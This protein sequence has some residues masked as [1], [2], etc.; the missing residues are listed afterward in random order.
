MKSE[1]HISDFIDKWPATLRAQLLHSGS[2]LELLANLGESKTFIGIFEIFSRTPL[3]TG[4]SPV[5][6]RIPANG[7]I[8]IDKKL[9]D[10]SEQSSSLAGYSLVVTS[11]AIDELPESEKRVK[12]IRRLIHDCMHE[13]LKFDELVH[14]ITTAARSLARLNLAEKKNKASQIER[15]EVP[16]INLKVDFSFESLTDRPQ[17]WRSS[18]WW[19]GE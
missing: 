5:M 10:S 4:T 3:P 17:D 8:D 2:H 7:H 15:K 18:H 9:I 16:L 11:K 6:F 14:D 13:A 19:T 1:A 12:N